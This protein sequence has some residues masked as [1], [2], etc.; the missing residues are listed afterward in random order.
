MR[1]VNRIFLSAT[2]CCMLLSSAAVAADV[3][4]RVLSG[5]ADMVTGGDALVETNAALEKFNARLNGQDITRSFRPGKTAGT[6]IARVEGLKIGKNTLEVKSAKGRAKLELTD[7]PTPGPVFSGPHQKPFV[8]QTEQAGLGAPL[9][10]DCSAKTIV[11]YVY[12][13]TQPAAPGGRGGQAPG[14]LPSGFKP[15]DP[16]TPRPADLAQ[17]TTSDGKTV[18]YI[19]RRERGTINRAIYEIAFLHAPG[20]PLPDPWNGTS[21]WNGRL[22]YSFGGGCAAGYRQGGAGGG[23]NDAQL[24]AGYATAL[25]SLNVF[26]NNCNDLISAETMMMVKEHFIEQFGVPVHT[27]GTG[28]SGGSMQQHLIAQNFPGLLDGITP[29]LSYSDITTVMSNVVDCSL[30]AHAFDT[31]TQMWTEEQKTAVSGFATWGTCAQSW[32]RSFS[33]AFVLATSCNTVVPKS[34][35]YDAKTNPTG[36]RCDLYDNQVNVFGRDPK[37]GVARRTLDNVG[38]QYG[39]MAFNAGKITTEQFLELNQNIGGFDQDGMIVADRTRADPIA[40]RTAYETGRVNS[41]GGSLGSIPIIDS[42]PY[43]D[44]TGDIHDSFRSFATRARLIASNG[45]ADNQ[46]ILRMPPRVAPGGAGALVDP[47]RLMDSW[48]DN[49]AKDQSKDSPAVKVAR[50]KPPEAADTCWTDTGEKIAEPASYASNGRCN[51]MYPPHADPRI[52]SG[53]PLADDVLKCVLRPIDVSEYNQTLASDQIGHLKSIFPDGVCD[54][55]RPGVEQRR[56]SGTW[57]TF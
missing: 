30:L 42:R 27:I 13:S 40:L 4:I 53:G 33:P 20:Q 32:N 24:A 28:A 5:R 35:M 1:P 17:T 22:V 44:P 46:I 37:T 54:Y 8:C 3:E 41:G 36:V 48:L 55:T 57:K 43:V 25:S 2:A 19:V 47:I 38:V 16:S 31:A 39:L 18:D 49:I 6:L 7:Y 15:F 11:T 45:R 23:I 14:A 51:Q 12:K 34:L 9:D 50:N 29:S 21:G 56:L 26:G 10:D 52:A